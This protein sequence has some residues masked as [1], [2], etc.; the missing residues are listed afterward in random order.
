MVR[1]REEVCPPG[2]VL[3]VL[4]ESILGSCPE[5]QGEGNT[6]HLLAGVVLASEMCCLSL[7]QC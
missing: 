2:V 6:F 4:T 5:R 1:P 7:V 3:N